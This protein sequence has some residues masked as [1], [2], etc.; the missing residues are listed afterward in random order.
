MKHLKIEIQ[1]AAD[2]DLL[3]AL[4]EV[5][6]KIKA[7]FLCGFDGNETGDYSFDMRVE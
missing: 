5:Q 2:S 3:L 4:D 1:G 7:G 6:Q